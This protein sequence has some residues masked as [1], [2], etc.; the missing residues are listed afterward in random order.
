VALAYEPRL[1]IGL[2]GSSGAGGA[3]ILRRIYGEQVENLAT[4]G[5]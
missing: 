3:K 4:S 5:E 2:I 1:A